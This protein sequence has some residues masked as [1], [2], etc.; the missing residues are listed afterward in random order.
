MTTTTISPDLFLSALKVVSE[1][2]AMCAQAGITWDLAA[3]QGMNA[4]V[5]WAWDGATAFEVYEALRLAAEEL[6]A[7]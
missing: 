4:C 1:E 2:R 7:E 3:S 6:D 5:L